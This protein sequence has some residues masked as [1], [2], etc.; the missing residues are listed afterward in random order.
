M[1]KST[2][3]KKRAKKSAGLLRR[4]FQLGALIALLG[5]IYAAWFW[6]EM[7]SWRPDA[8]L[9]PEQGT[10]IASGAPGVRFETLKATGADFVYLELTM[11]GAPPD[12]GFRDRLTAA[13]GAG[14]KVGVVQPFDP[15][16]RADP[17]SALFTRMVARDPQLL[18]PALSL[19]RLPGS[20]GSRVSEAAMRSEILTLVNQ[21]EMHTG[22][23]VILKVD[24]AFERQFQMAN[25]L[26]RDL[27][28]ARDRLRPRYAPRPWLLW[29]ANSQLVSEAVSAPLEWVVVQR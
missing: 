28:L 18:P 7:R 22:Q 16:Q 4:L 14:L 29:S 19:S 6:Y 25:S 9:Y 1:A 2:R 8:D 26:D 5:L 10:V 20:C 21:I 11:A 3:N 17:Q 15:C 23:S 12:P 27:W 24:A 13:R